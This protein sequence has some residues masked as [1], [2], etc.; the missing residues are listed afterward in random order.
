MTPMVI[1][2]PEYLKQQECATSP[3]KVQD[4]RRRICRRICRRTIA[5]ASLTLNMLKRSQ[6]Q[7]Q[8]KFEICIK[9]EE[10]QCEH[11]KIKK[12][13]ILMKFSLNNYIYIMHPSSKMS[14]AIERPFI[15]TQSH[16][17]RA[18]NG[19]LSDRDEFSSGI[20]PKCL[21]GHRSAD[22]RWGM[23]FASRY[24]RKPSS[25]VSW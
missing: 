12:W 9:A 24:D 2:L 4:C 16:N 19:F 15:E 14:S 3:P 20:S 8:T 22:H 7:I 21:I 1:F 10:E 13:D 23:S 5:C 17:D 11:Q 25:V 18:M 6:H